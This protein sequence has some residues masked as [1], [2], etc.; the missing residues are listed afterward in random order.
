LQG[1]ATPGEQK[2][3]VWGNTFANADPIMAF[4]SK[5]RME[6]DDYLTQ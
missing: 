3:Q 4:Q 1:N 2:A 5:C 6:N